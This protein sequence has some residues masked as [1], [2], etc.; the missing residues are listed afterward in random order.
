[1]PVMT[2][3]EFIQR[4]AQRS[5]LTTHPLILYSGNLT[6]ELE[7]QAQALGVYAVFPKPYGLQDLLDTVRQACEDP[8]A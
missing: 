3:I 5:Y 4:L 1:M 2:G 8:K 6:T 7:Q